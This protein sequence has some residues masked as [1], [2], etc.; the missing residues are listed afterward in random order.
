MCVSVCVCIAW[1]LFK[2]REMI[3]T[4]PEVGLTDGKTVL[5]LYVHAND[6]HRVGCRQ[7]LLVYILS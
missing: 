7:T 4:V 2:L 3:T 6:L 5:Q 1:H